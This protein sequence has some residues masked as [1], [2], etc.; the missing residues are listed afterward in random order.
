MTHSRSI[1]GNMC[2][3]NAGIPSGIT[4]AVL[5]G[6]DNFPSHELSCVKRFSP[7][8]PLFTGCLFQ[9]KG[10]IS[11]ALRCNGWC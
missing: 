3:H 8:P 6:L 11:L 4:L 7:P 5:S 2:E 9:Q 10:W 1:S